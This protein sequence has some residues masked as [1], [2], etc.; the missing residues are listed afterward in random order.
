MSGDGTLSAD[1]TVHDGALRMLTV[2][3]EYTKEVH[4]MRPERQIGSADFNRLVRATIAEHGAPEFIRSNNG[5]EFVTQKLQK[6]LAEQAIK[7]I[8]ITPASPWENG[9]VES[10]HSASAMSVPTANSSGPSPKRAS[11]PKSSAKTTTLSGRTV[12]TAISPRNALYWNDLYRSQA[13]GCTVNHH[14]N[15]H[16][17]QRCR[18]TLHLAQ[19]FGPAQAH[20]ITA[21]PDM[22]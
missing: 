9:F 3:D 2:L 4:L 22:H 19:F 13:M 18:L 7:T 12:R 21:Y 1:G 15:H 10:F 8:Y 20:K 16:T 5:P 17:D 11:S 14:R 6:W